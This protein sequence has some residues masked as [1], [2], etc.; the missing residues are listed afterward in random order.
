MGHDG[1]VGKADQRNRAL[2]GDQVPERREQS[3]HLRDVTLIAATV[4]FHRRGSALE[5]DCDPATQTRTCTGPEPSNPL[6]RP[7]HFTRDKATPGRSAKVCARTAP[8]PLHAS[9]SLR[10]KTQVGE[11]YATASRYILG[12]MSSLSLAK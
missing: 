9:L 6:P 5:C 7:P 10:R 8:T 1:P 2:R 4:P 3:S 11:R 12:R